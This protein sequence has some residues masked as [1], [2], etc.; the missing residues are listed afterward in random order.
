MIQFCLGS[1]QF[2]TLGFVVDQHHKVENFTPE[3]FWKIQVALKR[4]EILAEFHWE[5][6]HL[7]DK[8]ICFIIYEQCALNP[9]ATVVDVIS[10]ETRKWYNHYQY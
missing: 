9:M 4:E 7:F 6:N 2:P 5:R 1:C 10:K 3:E 8:E